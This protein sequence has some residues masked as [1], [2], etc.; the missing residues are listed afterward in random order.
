MS[1][2]NKHSK[3]MKK[4]HFLNYIAFLFLITACNVPSKKEFTIDDINIIPK[5]SETVLN[6]GSF[7]FNKKTKIVL[8][9]PS[10]KSIASDLIQQFK[11]STGIQ[12]SF[13]VK[14]SAPEN[15]VI[16]KKD[17]TL[18]KEAYHL[19]VTSNKVTIKATDDAGFLYGVQTLIQILPTEYEA[20]SL[21]QNIE[22]SIPNLEIKDKP[23]F[24][25]RGLMLDVS[26][27]FFRKEYVLKTI[28]R[29][30]A[31]KMNVLHLHLIDDQ[32]WRVEIKKYPKLTEV[33]AWRADKEDLHWNT[34]DIKR[35]TD[36]IKYGG[37]YTQEDIKEI[38]AYATSKQITVIPEIELPAHV[39]S[40]IAAYPHLSCKNEGIEVPSGGVWPITNIYCPGKE[41]TFEFLEDVLSEVLELF[42]SK[43]IHIGG[44]EA[45]KTLWKTCQHCQRRM[46]T[47]KLKEVEELQSYFVKRI[48]KFINS[49]GR[50]LVGWD[51]ILEGGLPPDATVMSWRGF[52]GGLE[53]AK[54]GHDV[55]MTP[56]EFCYVNLYQGPY[57]VEPIAQGGY[58]PLKK[59][60]QFEPVH[61]SMT[62]KEAK[63]VL[64]GQA[65]LWS[66]YVSTESHSEY[67]IFPRLAALSESLWSEKKNKDW[68]DFSSRLVIQFKRYKAQGINYSESAFLISGD[69]KVDLESK[70]ISL[71]LQNEFPES[72][73]RYVIDSDDISK[74][75]L[76]YSTA[77]QLT[78]TTRIK[79]SLFRNDKPVGRPYVKTIQFHK[80]MAKK[81][82]YQ[83]HHVK[84][85][86]GAGPVNLVDGL[87]GSK[88]FFDGKWQGWLSKD[89]E[90]TIDLEEEKDIRK[91]T[92]GAMEDQGPDIYY[93]I[94]IK[95]LTSLDGEKFTQQ[96]VFNR[97]YK[98]NPNTDLAEFG[99]EFPKKVTAKYIKV[100]VKALP[101]N[102][103][104]NRGVW[105]FVDEIIVE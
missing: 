25:W 101:K 37:F 52:K 70:T 15:V 84:K 74:N 66:E 71:L 56:G 86:A 11:I 75:T 8:S 32:G 23:R 13:A 44:D 80:A 78:K 82:S 76:K 5:P 61:E 99:L 96:V 51:E 54:E 58:L 39:A 35:P 93:P 94:Q 53:A 50:K 102:P 72:D 77:I 16:F 47:E 21:Q 40:A 19:T 14:N 92:V 73:I 31:H 105:L 9:T 87:R 65:N 7:T 3:N 38:V 29:L 57:D 91:V 33:G 49:N 45:T 88:N 12:I 69:T 85:Y 63:H 64:G 34:R 18:S 10:Q 24:G 46:R 17:T 100:I 30:A 62:L 81:V 67:M 90:V 36:S 95:V 22:W 43:Y 59:A 89:M 103:A 97:P 6:E 42:P 104:P 60:Y 20:N 26:R 55:V 1:N 48:E 98:A 4:I 68:A 83:T 79:A 28:D 27:H 41:S 2:I